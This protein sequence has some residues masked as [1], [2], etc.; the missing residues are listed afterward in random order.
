[1]ADRNIEIIV[2]IRDNTNGKLKGLQE[3]INRADAAAQRLANRFKNFAAMRY[4]ATLNLID[5]VTTPATRINNLLRRLAGTAYRISI[6]V[7]DGALSK[8]RSIESAI[9]KIAGKTHRIAFAVAGGIG[10]KLNGL[11]SGALMGAGA[12]MPIAGMAGVGFGV[13]NAI[14]SY[15]D[16]EKTMSNVQAIRQLSKD[17]PEMQA[18]TQ[19]A[20]DLGAQTAW[21]RKQVGEGQYYQA[22]AGWETEQ[23]LKST[24]HI[25]NLASAGNMDLGR[26]SDIVTDS[27]TAFQI[28]A[29]ETYLNKQGKQVDAI[30]HYVDMLAKLQAVS[31]TDI[32]QAG[33]AFKY[34]ANVI[35]AMFSREN[36]QTRMQATED[37]MIMTGL[38]ANAGIKGSMAGTSLRGI[39]TRFSAENRNALFALKDMLGVEVKDQAGN[40]YLP[41]QIMKN[42][43]KRIREG[44]S[45]EQLME[46][47]EVLA[48]EKVHADTRRKVSGFLEST[49]KNGGK[50]GGAELAKAAAMMAGQEGMSGLLAVLMGD[51]EA[52]EAKLDNVGG[53]ASDTAKTQLDNLAG[54]F[55]KLG[56][57][58]DAFQQ[59]FFEGSAGDGLR[60]FVDT[61]TELVTRANNLFKDGIQLDDI[62]A[63]IGDVVGKLKAKFLELD[64]VGSILAG[65]ALMAALMKIASTAQRVTASIRGINMT[66]AAT[67]AQKIG[68]MTVSAG[69][70][71]VNGKVAGGGVGGVGG[72]KV[73]NQ[74]IID[75]YYRTKSGF[76]VNA[77]PNRF[78]GIGSAAG[79]A[80]AF[81]GIFG[82]LDLYSVHK[83]GQERIANAAP[84]EVAQVRAQVHQEETIAAGGMLGSIA[85][86]AAGAAIGSLAGP[87]GT[88]IGGVIGG[89]LGDILG[90]WAGDKAPNQS[91]GIN[92]NKVNKLI[93]E[94]MNPPQKVGDFSEFSNKRSFDS[95][96]DL[97]KAPRTHYDPIPTKHEQTF[98]QQLDARMAELDAQMHA[99]AL[100][101]ARSRNFSPM[102]QGNDAS[103]DLYGKLPEHLYGKLPEQTFNVNPLD[104][105]DNLLFNKTEAAELNPEQMAQMAAME[106][107]EFMN[108]ESIPEIN[109]ESFLENLYSQIEVMSEGIGELMSGLGEQIIESLSAAFESVGEVMGTFGESINEHLVASFEG[110]GEIFANL[111]ETMTTSATSAL[112]GVATAF[113]SARENIMST[114]SELPGF[115]SGVFS[116]LGGAAESAGS[117]I[118]AGLTS[119]IGSIIGAWQSAA[120][121]MA[122]SA[123]ASAGAALGIG[124]HAEGGF[125]THPEI[126]LVGEA[127]SELILPLTDRQRSLE[128]LSQA[129]GVLGL[130]SEENL[131]GGS[132]N[133]MNGGVNLGGMNVMFEINGAQNPEEVMQTIR[134]NL[135]S[136]ADTLMATLS[137]KL[138]AAFSNRALEV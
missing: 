30:E 34:G 131:S 43:Q 119:V 65:G 69:V 133:N 64:G 122:S 41:G 138:G 70:V 106:H 123:G 37:A 35:G 48:G 97:S 128:L 109:S 6:G 134:A 38:M 40:L 58:W 94:H 79:S 67:S 110:V 130:N 86:A 115:F 62:G 111:G 72:R 104:W 57:A 127:G 118:Y 103:F 84:S 61:L 5:R 3:Q 45:P 124:A 85:G 121:T 32:P 77:A 7:T 8:I 88:A 96:A 66:N 54:S 1:M 53:T 42:L 100:E 91:D 2:D 47:M 99:E 52:M 105:L 56:S 26:A 112:E 46:S 113:T 59:S 90:R 83:A 76:N 125:V 89:M 93:T 25:L 82:A 137:N 92:E 136:L 21:T 78:A 29:G 15:A 14:K 107:G 18:L 81:A 126:A 101:R 16:F 12:F 116:G 135:E 22:L 50:I 31:N 27:A 20:K 132:E 10:N 28:R 74:A 108:A 68:T 23:I 39:M 51:W 117:A 114:W 98:Q 11:A 75:N 55:T 71:N 17:S 129:S 102:W 80:A 4:Q 120:S 19:Q 95:Y 73:G 49:L 44:I 87:L 63:L 33:E 60:S 9:M 24:P 13:A 36:I